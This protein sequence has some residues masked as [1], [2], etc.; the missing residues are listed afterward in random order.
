MKELE[1]WHPVLKSNLLKRLPIQIELNNTKIVLFRT[2]EKVSALM[3]T[4]PHRRMPL[5]KGKIFHN[6]IKCAYH[7]ICFDSDGNSSSI[8]ESSKIQ[9]ESFDTVELHNYIW[10][11]KKNIPA[12]FPF[13]DIEGLK[14]I[15]I[16]EHEIFAPLELVLDN[17]TEVE[18]TP[19]VHLFLGYDKTKMN[20]IKVECMTEEETVRIKNI[21]PQKKIPTLIRYF[22]EIGENDFFVDDWTTYFSPIY[23]VYEQYWLDKNFQKRKNYFKIY[24]FFNPINKDKTKLI[25]FTFFKYS[26]WKNFALNLF[27]K[28]ILSQIVQAEIKR[29]KKALEMIQDKNPNVQGMKL[30]R[31]DKSLGPNRFRIKKIYKKEV[32]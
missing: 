21:G 12:K 6:K 24:V 30:T 1:H 19:E 14:Q 11:K 8:E 3:D 2:E 26:K 17:F 16:S 10:I 9:A 4:C 18:H 29:D 13:F 5:S 32:L 22:L 27:I 28:P 20:E 15:D 31:F 23:S 7:G 25:V